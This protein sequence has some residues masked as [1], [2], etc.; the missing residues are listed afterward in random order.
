MI[1]ETT[2]QAPVYLLL[3][4]ITDDG[5]GNTVPD[6][7]APSTKRL[8]GAEIQSRASTT[9]DH[10]ADESDANRVY[11]NATLIVVSY[12]LATLEQITSASRVQ[13]GSDVWRVFGQPIIK[14][15]L[16]HGN[17]H[18]VAELERSVVEGPNA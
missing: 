5:Y 14:R 6:W 13:Q 2:K 4:G 10:D 1:A 7:S 15:G 12:D 17:N 3:P 8:Y 16:M 18:L 11:R 9:M